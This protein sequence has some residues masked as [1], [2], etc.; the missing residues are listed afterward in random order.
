MSRINKAERETQQRVIKL[1]TERL[2]YRYLGD[3]TDTD[4]SCI[5][6]AVLTAWLKKRG[7]DQQHI[8]RA[9]EKLKREALN[10]QRK[11]YENNKTVYQLLR[12]GVQV[13]AQAGQNTE[14]IHLIDW[15]DPDAN[16]FAIAEEVTLRGNLERRPDLVLYINGIAFG[17]I[18]LKRSTVGLSEGI[19]QLL[20]NQQEHFNAWFFSTVQIVLAGNDTQGLRY[21]T[22][23]TQEK[24]FLTW[25]EDEQEN[26][27]YKLDKYLAKMCDKSRITEIMHDFI[28]FDDGIKKLPRVHQYFGVKASQEHINNKRGGVIW[29]TQG[30]G[31]SI[32][33]VLL[34]K[35]IL[36]NKPNARILIVTDRDELDK[37]IA[38][39][40]KD[41]GVT[42][43]R[44]TSGADLITKLSNP[45]PRL[46]CSLVHKFGRH[47]VDDHDAFIR[48]IGNRPPVAVGEIFIF[49]DE[50]HRTQSGKLHK[51]MKALLPSAV[52]IGFTGT[53]LLK[54]DKATSLEVFGNYIHTYKFN[55]AVEDGVV[56]DLIYEARDIPQE[57]TA[58]DRIDQW[59]DAKTKGLNDW[60]KAALRE[61]WG[62]MQNVLS[63]RS[64]MERVVTDIVFDFSTKQ[65]L[66]SH[67]G[68]ALLVASSIYEACKYYEL[69]E[70]TELKGKCAVITSYVPN[71]QHVTRE[72][73]GANTETEKQFIY[74]L[75]TKLLENVSRKGTKT[76]TEV[77]E[78]DA[79]QQFIDQPARMR[80][81]IVV[82]KLL[83]GFDAPSC[84]YLYIDKK[85]QDHGLFQAICRTNRLDGE[86][87][88]FG[89]I[90]DYK[91]LF[92]KVKGAISVYT[93]QLDDQDEGNK[94][95]IN[96]QDR[97]D[98]GRETLEA[99]REA[100]GKL[101]EPVAMPKSELDHIRYFCGNSEQPQDLAETEPLRVALYK[102]V[103]ILMRAYA[104]IAEDI[105]QAQYTPQEAANIAVE[106]ERAIALRDVI[107]FASGEHIELKAYEADMRYLIDTYIK[108]EE[109]RKISHFDDVGLLDLIVKSGIADAVNSLPSGVSKSK[110]AVAETIANNVRRAILQ[111]RAN[112]PA[113]YDKMSEVLDDVIAKLRDER[114]D[115][116]QFMQEMAELA[117]RVRAGMSDNTP[118]ALD[119][120]GKRALYNNLKDDEELA[121]KIDAAVR[122]SKPA[123]FRGNRVKEN[124]IKQAIYPLL[125][126]DVDEVERIFQII[127]AQLEY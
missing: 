72:E 114:L 58:Q 106:V 65:R 41:A 110:S 26:D 21:G 91:D 31:K 28:L 120:A 56:L 52:F 103:A 60:Q 5:E 15:A 97:L 112:N 70:K 1:F 22:I 86:D 42:I 6:E 12:Y 18:E 82:D 107:R 10:P 54:E 117:A 47:G 61:Q 30:S 102:C 38:T 118:V 4:N 48:D 62:T 16:D 88:T 105:E 101:C 63:S 99:A 90:V 98:K 108:A 77:Y 7:I 53:P 121:L 20:S 80:L 23:E 37:Q 36:E 34:A 119:T 94:S 46:L 35:W 13:Q 127:T 93:K 14:T 40:F 66:V 126:D 2:G 76:E 50:C 8:N 116:E 57:I 81:L 73:T 3:K 67:R 11:L 19:G 68:N 111:Q 44:A 85:M 33:M 74:N 27:S 32:V 87:K 78:D 25:K 45:L 75:Y 24:Y 95:Q 84:T 113:F 89:Y 43:A 124:I 51:T 100:F 17:V 115:Y 71:A 49:V 59:F 9:A 64:R 69:F 96:M 123:D 55:E 104:A 83:T 39:V 29:H 92:N 122:R 125:N 79:K 109:A